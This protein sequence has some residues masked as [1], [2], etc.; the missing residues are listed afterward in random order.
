MVPGCRDS[1]TAIEVECLEAGE[2]ERVFCVVEEIAELPL[3]DPSLQP[4]TQRAEN[5]G[6]VG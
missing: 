1:P 6:K 4:L 5:G 3:T 2:G